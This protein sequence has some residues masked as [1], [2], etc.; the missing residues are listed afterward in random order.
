MCAAPCRLVERVFWRLKVLYDP[1]QSRNEG[2]NVYK[3]L[4]KFLA[5]RK[6]IKHD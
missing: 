4:L 6:Y 2:L 3:V 1:L 5:H